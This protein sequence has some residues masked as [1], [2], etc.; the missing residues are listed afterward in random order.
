MNKTT[1]LTPSLLTLANNHYSWHEAWQ[2]LLLA[3]DMC[4]TI[5][6]CIIT[7]S[8]CHE[9][10]G[11]RY[12]KFFM[13]VTSQWTS[14]WL[15]RPQLR[16][17]LSLSGRDGGGRE[18]KGERGERETKMLTVILPH[19]HGTGLYA[20]LLTKHRKA[21]KYFNENRKRP[22]A[23][24]AQFS[25]S[26]ADGLTHSGESGYWHIQPIKSM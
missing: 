5:V 8:A 12:H 24:L 20:Y 16:D 10:H 26:Y 6:H 22:G 13:C 4:G 3:L 15:S 17:R 1:V 14:P 7:Y 2:L 11:F 19:N 23:I 21:S 25:D 18:G 9:L